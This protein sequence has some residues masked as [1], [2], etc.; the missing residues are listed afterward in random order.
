MKILQD[1]KEEIRV[2]DSNY[3]LKVVERRPDA[4][5]SL[6]LLLHGLGER[7]LRIYRKLIRYLP[8]SSYVLAPDG[9]FHLDKK[10][11]GPGTGHA[12]YFF[13]KETKTYQRDQTLSLSLLKN[14]LHSSNPQNLPITIIGFSQG[15]YL[16]PQVGF[17]D[18]NIRQVIGI[19]CEFRR[20]F[21]I[22]KPL[23]KLMAIHGE[24]DS[25]VPYTLAQNEIKRLE[26]EGINVS[27]HLLPRLKHEISHEVGLEIEKILES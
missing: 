8:E 27:W 26:Q 20:H 11:S 18:K 5:L 9:P 7:G 19:G 10:G 2:I 15:G 1:I 21:F 4:P 16:A 12:W 17:Q 22:Q 24:L 6:I 14:L 13:D 25:I 23:F 3:S